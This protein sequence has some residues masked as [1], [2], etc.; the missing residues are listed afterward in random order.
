MRHTRHAVTH[1][2]TA[3]LTAEAVPELGA[4]VRKLVV[5]CCHATTV[6]WLVPGAGEAPS[7]RWR[8]R[9]CSCTMPANAA[10]VPSRCA[11][12]PG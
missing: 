8:G 11:G 7:P 10:P 5:D 9:W 3:T 12:A 4:G 6:G 1:T 2:A